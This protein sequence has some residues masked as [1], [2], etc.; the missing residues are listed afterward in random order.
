MTARAPGLIF[1]T[2]PAGRCD[3][4]R[5]GGAVVDHDAIGGQWR[6]WYY[7]RDA[8][9]DGP[10]TLGTGR[11]A[12]ATSRDGIDWNRVDGPLT[13]GAVFEPS[14]DPAD[15]DS[16]HVGLTDVSR[17]AG[18]WLMWYFGGD[19]VIRETRALGPVAGL[20]MRPGLARSA[21]GI[22]WRRVRGAH[23]TGALFGWPE[24]RLY[25]A[26][27]NVLHDGVRL[28]LHYTAPTA[29]LARF[30]TYVATSKNGILW[31]QHGLIEWADGA[32]AYDC[33]GIVTRQVMPNPL[34]GGRRFL[35]VYTA[36]DAAHRRSIA[37][38]ESDDGFRWCRLYGE[39]IFGVGAPGAWDELGVAATRL[40]VARDLLHLY[41]YG[42]QS[43]GAGEGLRGIG[44]AT[45]PFGDLRRLRR[46]G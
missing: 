46:F 32:Q 36:T 29:D 2:G 26:W 15:F 45:A 20:G 43:L 19:A 9:F 35:M 7:C 24:D 5:V 34:K 22:H 18:E 6:M 44:L 25:A 41:Y 8:T 21:D 14:G 23:P 37:A 39:P 3:D 27:P 28:I 17:G 42:F 13:R 38:A 10:S 33:G 40:V 1:G 12:F 30:D 31:R 16:L 4:Y 11:I